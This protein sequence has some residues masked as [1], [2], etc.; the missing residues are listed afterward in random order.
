MMSKFNKNEKS[1]PWKNYFPP[2]FTILPIL[3][4]VL[5]I[6]IVFGKKDQQQDF[7][8]VIRIMR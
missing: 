8:E 2:N 3:N 5:K 4:I 1:D 6:K 7:D